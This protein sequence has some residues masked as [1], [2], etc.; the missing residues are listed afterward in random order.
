MRIKYEPSF[1]AT[2]EIIWA[3][4]IAW[5]CATSLITTSDNAS[6]FCGVVVVL[7]LLLLYRVADIATGFQAL[8]TIVFD[9]QDEQWIMRRPH[10]IIFWFIAVTCDVWYNNG[11]LLALVFH[12]WGIWF[13]FEF[14]YAVY[15]ICIYRCI[16]AIWWR[17]ALSEW[18]QIDCG[19]KKATTTA[20]NTKLFKGFTLTKGRDKST[21]SPSLNYTTSFNKRRR[22]HRDLSFNG[23]Q[24]NKRHSYYF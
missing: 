21:F 18:N 15:A 20:A 8:C 9:S 3:I 13:E 17:M 12:G 23:N 1:G 19:D 24:A 7:L 16:H 22:P 2:N 6:A 10:R 11:S 14:V 4:A 5:K